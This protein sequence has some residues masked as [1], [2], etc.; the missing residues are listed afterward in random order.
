MEPV[1][2]HRPTSGRWKVRVS[3]SADAS[4]LA[5]H[6]LATVQQPAAATA[7]AAMPQDTGPLSAPAGGTSSSGAPG[8]CGASRHTAASSNSPV[9]R[10]VQR[11][12]TRSAPGT[13]YAATS[14]ARPTVASASTRG[15][16]VSRGVRRT[17]AIQAAACVEP[18][19][20][21]TMSRPRRYSPRLIGAAGYSTA[22][23]PPAPGPR[24]CEGLQPSAA[25]DRGEDGDLV[26][27]LDGRVEPVQEA[28]VLAA[29]VDVH[30]AAQ[31][32]IDG[33][34]LA[35]AVEAVVEAVQH[36][37]DRGRLVDLRLG[38]AASDTAQLR[39][40]LHRDCHRRDIT[41]PARRRAARPSRRTR[42]T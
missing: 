13:R 35:Q 41:K 11:D 12:R 20:A 22:I 24:R 19:V 16:P 31:V 32:A 27:V 5:A 30:E 18:H 8:V 21:A 1:S 17:I 3:M 14:A 9:T 40:D 15:A 38:L 26:A 25:G 28:D 29:H 33:D 7:S 39:R 36:L 10:A 6:T 4:R 42:R 23:A 2:S 37:A 34:P